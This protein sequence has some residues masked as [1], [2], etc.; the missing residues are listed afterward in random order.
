[1]LQLKWLVITKYK[2]QF[3]FEINRIK[4]KCVMCCRKR[5]EKKHHETYDLLNCTYNMQCCMSVT[6]KSGCRK[7]FTS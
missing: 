1:M 6:V 5:D 3:I 7:L 2:T 4:K